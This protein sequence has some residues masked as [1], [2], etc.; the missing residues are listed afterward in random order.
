MAQCHGTKMQ[1]H[2]TKHNAMTPVTLPQHKARHCGTETASPTSQKTAQWHKA[3]P[4][5]KAQCC[6]R[7]C[8]AVAHKTTGMCNIVAKNNQDSN[9]HKNLHATKAT[10]AK[11]VD[12]FFSL[13]NS[14]Y[15]KHNNQQGQNNCQYATV[16]S[17]AAQV[18]CF[19][20]L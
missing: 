1:H 17:N 16:A 6:S 11:Q 2:D 14:L 7:K 4:Q 3:K 8:N 12:C 13:K 10:K 18:D 5:Q 9:N 19:L 15:K 20:S